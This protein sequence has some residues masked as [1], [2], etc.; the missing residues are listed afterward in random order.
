LLCF[1]TPDNSP[2]E[3]CANARLA[4]KPFRSLS[5]FNSGFVYLS[6]DLHSCEE[7]GEANFFSYTLHCL[8]D[9]STFW[10]TGSSSMELFCFL[11]AIVL[12]SMGMD[13]PIAGGEFDLWIY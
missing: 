10:I 5:S 11:F 3:A 12:G 4:E 1:Y 7:K 8:S 2:G 13:R 9:H 6:V